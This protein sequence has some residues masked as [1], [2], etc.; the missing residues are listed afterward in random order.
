MSVEIIENDIFFFFFSVSI[1]ESQSRV[2]IVHLLL[3]NDFLGQQLVYFFPNDCNVKFSP[4]TARGTNC[5][6]ST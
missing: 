5:K 2:T 6:M 3:C 4:S 1:S